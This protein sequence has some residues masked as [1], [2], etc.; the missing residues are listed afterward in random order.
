MQGKT[1]DK[2]TPC[3]QVTEARSSGQKLIVTISDGINSCPAVIIKPSQPVDQYAVIKI[4]ESL[5][6]TKEIVIIV[7]YTVEERLDAVI[8]NPKPYATAGA[9]DTSSSDKV[10]TTSTSKSSSSSASTSVQPKAKK[11]SGTTAA[12]NFYDDGGMSSILDDDKLSNDQAKPI[13]NL[14]PY[15]KVWVIKA[16]VTQ[17]SDM[18]HWDKGTSKG[19]LFSIELLDEYGGQIRATFFNDVAKKYY[20]AIKERSVYFFSGGKLKDANRKFTTIPHPYEITFDRDTVI[21]NA[22]DSEIP[23][24]TFNCTR[25]CDMT[26]VE[27]NMILD[28]AGVVQNI[29]E[30]KEFTTKNNRK[31]KR[32]NISLIDDSSS[33]FCTVDLTIWGDM[34]DTHD[35]QQ[36]DVVI[37]KSVRKSNYGGVSLNTINST[38][39]FKDPGIPIYQQLSEWYQNNEGSFDGEGIKLT[40][41]Q[42]A[43]NSERTFKRKN[44]IADCKNMSVDTVTAPDYLTIRAYVSYIKHELWYDAC[45][46]KECNKKVQQ[47]EGIYHCSSCN[48]SSDT[49]TR[50]FLANL[51]ITDWTGKQYCNAFNQAVE[52]LFSD[53]TADDMC[54]RAAEPEYMPYLLGEKTFT[55]YV[56]TVRVTTETTKEPKL[57]FTIIRVTPIDYA[58]EAKSILSLIRDYDI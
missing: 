9:S 44:V 17:K 40:Q 38:R 33:P 55:R 51:G 45:T 6:H 36:G 39:I 22:R 49:C 43:V 19:S 23:T 29:G 4:Y 1:M 52:K 41:K 26:N 56:F 20:D 12:D 50:K 16:R 53:M 32:C 47:N 28:V 25:L 15:D 34:C 57:K 3:V 46:N 10:K 13:S 54:A 18:K 14:N 58:R 8:G 31:T 5:K 48:H 27:D 35:M 30:T 24:D 37:L 2:I 11:S 21:Q 7:K 42:A